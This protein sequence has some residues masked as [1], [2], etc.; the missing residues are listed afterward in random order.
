MDIRGKIKK[1][2]RLQIIQGL[3]AHAVT[4]Q[5]QAACLSVPDRKRKH[6]MQHLYAG[7][8]PVRIGIQDH[9][10]IAVRFELVALD[11]QLFAQFRVVIYGPIEHDG[12]T[13]AAIAHRLM[14]LRRQVY[15]RQSAMAEHHRVIAKLALVIGAAPGHL[16]RHSLND[17]RSY[18]FSG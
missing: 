11:D 14:A 18:G 10:G 9:L 6:A 4:R 12:I 17:G 5:E 8:T 15:D 13:P 1:T 7:F 3:D 2:V 16:S